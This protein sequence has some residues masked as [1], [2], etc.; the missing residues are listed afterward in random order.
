MREV[1]IKD[2][3]DLSSQ[4]PLPVVDRHQHRHPVVA[5]VGRFSFVKG[6]VL[7]IDPTLNRAS[8][9]DLDDVCEENRIEHVEEL[10]EGGPQGGSVTLLRE[11]RAPKDL[12]GHL[13]R[14]RATWVEPRELE[15]VVSQ[16][17]H[18]TRDAIVNQ[19]ELV[20]VNRPYKRKVGSC[21]VLDSLLPADLD[22]VL[23]APSDSIRS[24]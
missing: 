1:L 15:R 17:A 9:D 13:V 10:G 7:L 24:R 12:V 19:P 21:G 23:K 6:S 3:L 8:P 4:E 16:V 20:P 14:V 22:E 18:N 5:E 11:E 2:G